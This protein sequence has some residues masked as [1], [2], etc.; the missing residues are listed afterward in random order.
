MHDEVLDRFFVC[1]KYSPVEG[2]DRQ[3]LFQNFVR[4]IKLLHDLNHAN[5]VRVFNYY[6]YPDHLAGY[7]VM[8]QVA[9]S[10][11]VEHIASHPEQINEIFEQAINGFAHLESNRILHRDIRETNL[12]VTNDGVVKII[13]LGFGKR[14]QTTNDF[15]KSI[16]LNWWCELPS[17]FAQGT[18]DFQTEVYFVGKLFEKLIHENVI[19]HFKYTSTLSKMCQRNPKNRIGSF[20]D[21]QNLI[22]GNLFLEIDFS[23]AE[24]Y[25]YRYFA[26]SVTERLV[27]LQHGK[28][29]QDIERLKTGLESAYRT[30]ML[31]EH[32]PNAALVFG[33][34]LNGAYKYN[35]T[36]FP[37]DALKGFVHLLKTV[38]NEK[39]RILLSNLHTRL[40]AIDPFREQKKVGFDDMDDDI[41]F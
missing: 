6:I 32:V 22:V 13:D 11:L 37:V 12:M 40:N 39:Q 35:R 28:I 20:A 10:D 9:G 36:G 34:L 8:E 31:E 30:V 19:D 21:I 3:A 17:E 26:D 15:D 18:Y 7:I 4:E 27:T 24:R 29:T 16:S 1:K 25:A 41:P 23:D 14:V 38:S 33:V 5:V 2:L